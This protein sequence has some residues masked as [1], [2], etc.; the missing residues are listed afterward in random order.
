MRASM[1]GSL[2]GACLTSV[3]SELPEAGVQKRKTMS[4][5]TDEDAMGTGSG[6]NPDCVLD[7][8]VSMGCLRMA[9]EYGFLLRSYGEIGT[10][11]RIIP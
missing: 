7:D 6:R 1:P 10:V 3:D 11:G 9:L 8:F 4:V 2:E 5:F